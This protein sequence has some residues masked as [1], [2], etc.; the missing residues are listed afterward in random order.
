VA[1]IVTVFGGTGFLGRLIV[2]R[3][4]NAIIFAPGSHVVRGNRVAIG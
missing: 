1:Q 2:R 4:L 3:L